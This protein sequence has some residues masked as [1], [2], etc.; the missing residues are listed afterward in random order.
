EPGRGI[1]CIEDAAVG[2]DGAESDAP[3]LGRE[4]VRCHGAS[5]GTPEPQKHPRC[6]DRGGQH[7]ARGRSVARGRQGT[8]AV[9]AAVPSHRNAEYLRRLVVD[10]LLVAGTGTRTYGLP[11]VSSAV[12]TNL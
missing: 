5:L 3:G 2:A 11:L 8:A 9:R 1:P 6:A 4:G 12:T 10:L 7:S